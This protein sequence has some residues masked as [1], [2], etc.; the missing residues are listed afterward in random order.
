L[1]TAR[2]RAINHLTLRRSRRAGGKPCVSSPS[3]RLGRLTLTA[4]QRGSTIWPRSTAMPSSGSV[5]RSSREAA[6]P[7]SRRAH[8]RHPAACAGSSGPIL[9][10]TDVIGA[11]MHPLYCASLVCCSREDHLRRGAPADRRRPRACDRPWGFAT[12]NG[13][14]LARPGRKD[15]RGESPQSEQPSRLEPIDTMN[16][17]CCVRR[18]D[19]PPSHGA[20]RTRP[21]E[22]RGLGQRQE[23]H[24]VQGVAASSARHRRRDP[25][26]R[27]SA[28]T[29]RRRQHQ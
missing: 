23:R 13:E 12:P 20:P 6:G 4:W 18:L 1:R 29:G 3:P 16:G 25:A 19:R 8:R 7:R 21:T 28:T 10:S 15:R 11:T 22:M 5:T 9:W 27:P 24:H 2:C 26:P 17:S 14:K